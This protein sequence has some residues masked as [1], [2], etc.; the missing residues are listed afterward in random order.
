MH[1]LIRIHK[2]FHLPDINEPDVNHPRITP[3]EF[4]KHGFAVI[5]KMK[6]PIMYGSENYTD[7]KLLSLSNH[8]RDINSNITKKLRSDP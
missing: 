1:Q 2:S 5:E 6:Q 7:E 4:Q 3:K 8:F